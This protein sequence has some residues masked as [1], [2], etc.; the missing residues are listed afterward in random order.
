MVLGGASRNH[1]DFMIPLIKAHHTDVDVECIWAT[2]R[3]R[4]QNVYGVL[5]KSVTMDIN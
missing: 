3:R 2:V 1:S 4:E 5:F